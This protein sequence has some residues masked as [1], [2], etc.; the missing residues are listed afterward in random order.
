MHD[1]DLS[2]LTPMERAACYRIRAEEMRYRARKAVN[3]QISGAFQKIAAEWLRMACK[4]EEEHSRVSV[5]VES[6]L[7]ILLSRQTPP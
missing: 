6:E 7:A 1:V 5:A 2:E 4:I 3:D